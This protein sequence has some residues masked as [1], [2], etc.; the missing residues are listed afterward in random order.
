MSLSSDNFTAAIH[1]RDQARKWKNISFLMIIAIIL[2]VFRVLFGSSDN[3]NRNIDVGDY[4]ASVN[5]DGIIMDDDYRSEVLEKIAKQENIKAVIVNVDSPGGGIVGSENLYELLSEIAKTKPIVTVMGSVATSGGYMASLASDHIIARN[6]SLTGSIGV[7]IQAS[8][9]TNLANKMGVKFLT[10]K[11]SPLKGAPSPFEKANP[12]ADRVI[13]ESVKDSYKFF[14]DLVKKR[15]GEK[16][17]NN[18]SIITD[19]RIFTGRQALRVGLIDEIGGKAEA[20]NYL[21]TVKKIDTDKF[22]VKKVNLEK[23]NSSFLTKFIGE[24]SM[25]KIIQNL[26]GFNVENKQLMSVWH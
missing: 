4:I 8:E 10:Y 11:S 6:G 15:R 22:P 21:K 25:T 24:E 14:A 26:T 17:K 5:I 19:G 3:V 13:N 18:L 1:L 9:F 12:E 7:I 23:P 16:I 20:I 2:L